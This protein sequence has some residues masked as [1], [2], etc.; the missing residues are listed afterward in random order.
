MNQ[1][2]DHDRHI[3]SSTATKPKT[4]YASLSVTNQSP[5]DVEIKYL[6][7]G[8]EQK[9][10]FPKGS[11]G[12]FDVT[13]QSSSVPGDIEF[14]AYQK[15]TSTIVKMNGGESVKVTPTETKN[16]VAV[17]IGEGSAGGGGGQ[18]KTYYASL[19]VTNQ[20]PNDVEIK[21]LVNGQ[22]QKQEFPKGSAGGFD[23]TVQSSSVP[24][25]I[26]F[27]AYQKGTSTIVK[28]NGGESVKVTPTETKNAVAVTIGEGS[29]G[30]G[31]GQAKTY[32]ASLSVTNQSPNDVEIKY[33]VNGQ[34]QKQEF[35]K[36]SAGG[37][38]VTVQS[39]SVPGDIEF[40]AYQKGT[41]TIVKMNGGESVKVTPTETKN[42]VAVTIGE[43]SAGGGGGQ[44]KT[45]YASLSVTNQ[46]PN[47]VEI[48]Y[49][50]NGQEQKQEFPKG[51]AGGFDVTVQSSSVPGDI[52][53]KAYQKGT[54]TIVKMNGG[55]S[56][57]VTPT[58]TKNAVAV[59]IG[60][61]SAGGGG[62]QAKTYYA[63]LSV[64]NQSPNDV[65]IKYLVNGQEQKQ[66]FPK[67]SAGGF[68]VTVQS[69]SVP[70]DIEFKA[71][72]KGTS[73]IVKM[74]GGESVKVTPTETKNAVAVTIGEGSA[75][76]GGGQA[77]TYYA[78]L[79]VTN[80]SPNDVE[81]KYLVNGQEQK[82]EFPKGS[83]GGFDVTVQSSSV[84]GDIE[85]KA[86]Q[87]GTS[88]IV[89]MNG[90]ES[91]KVT[92]TETKNA[93]AVTIGE[94]S[95]GGGGG[96]AKT[97]YASLSVTNQ[98]PNDVEI[99]YLVNGQEQ[100][101][102]FPK[103]S[104]GGF[105]VTVQSSSVPGD[106]EFKAYQKGT[107]TIVK[108]NGGESVKV[109]PTETKNAVAVTIGEG[110]AGGG[111]GQAKTYY[112]SLSV[113]NQSPNDVEIKYLVNGQEQKQEFPKGSAGGF[114]VTVQSSSV[115]G[116]IEFKAYQKGTST[117]VKMNGGESVKVT[118]TETKNAVAVTI[119]EGSAGGGGGQA[120]TYYASLSVTNQSPNDVEIKYLVNGQEQKQEFPKGSA[121][122]FDVTV[123]SSSVPGDI[124]FK[125]YQKGTS[126]IVK[127]NGGESVKVTPTETKN[128]V[129]VTIG[130]GSAGGGGGQA[131]TYYASLSVTNQ[132][133]NDVEIKYL[134][135][136]QEQKQE[137]PKGS[138]G[139][140]DVTVQS[141]SVPG[142]IEFKAYQKGTSTIVKMNGGESVKVTPTET[143][144]AVAV[145]IGEGSAGG[146]GGQAKTYYASLSVTNQSPNDVEIKYLVNGQ[147]QKQEFPK[148]SAGGFDVTVQSSS[149]P[150]DIEFKAYQKGTSTIVKMNGGE[151]VKVT[152]TETKNAVAVTI[153]EGSAGG[154]GGQAKTYYASLSVTNQSPNDVE[155]KYLVNGQEQKQEFPKGSA[156]GF[157]VTVQSSSVPGDIEFK[158]Y[159]K[160]TS[161]IVKMNGGES[162]KVTPTETK[163]AVA[164]TI[165]EGSAGGGGGQAK[166]YYASLSVTNQSPNDV[167]IKYLVNGQEQKQEFPKGSAGG[168][169]VTVQSS[170]V[171][172]DIEFKAYQKGTSTIV[173]MNG[174]ESVKVTPTE[175]KNAVAVTIGEGSAGGGGGQAKT[176]YASLSVTNQSPNDVEI[177]YL[178]NGQEQKQE[179]PKGSAGGFDVTVQSSSVPGDIEFKA[180]QKGT[181]TIV[182]MN[183]GESVKVTPTETKN[184]VAVTIGEGSAGG[185]GGQAK[186]YY[187]SLSVT[188]QSPNDVEIKYLVNGQEQKQEFPKGSAGGFDVTVQSSSVPG[189]IEFKA[190]QKGTSTIVKMNGG[191]SVKVTPTETKNAVAVTI[192]E[193]SAGG[194]GGQAKTYY[195]SLSVT[196]QSPNDVEIKYLVNGQ[197]QKQEFPKGSAG[198]FDVT[199][200]S[201]SVPG[202]I[203][204]KAYQ[205]G[206]STIVK[207]NG[208][209]SVKVTPTETKNAVAVTIGEGSAGGGGGQ[210]KTYYASLSVTNQSPNDVEIKYLVNGQEQ[211]QEFPKGSAG[212]FDVTVQSSSVPGDI[213]FK[214][215]QKGTSTIVKMNGGESV[216]V[217]P[218][219][220]KNAVAV[221]IGEGSAGG[222]GGQ[223]KTYYASLSVTN[224]SP[225]D[226]E[227]K[228]LVNG[229]EQKQEF[230]KGSAGGFDV[231]VQSS[232]VP[233]DIE[234]KAYQKGTS[235]IVKMN[236]GESV[237]VTPTETKNAV[238]VT[239]GEGSAGGGGGQAKTYY[240][241]LSVT[242]QS[243][244]DVEIKYLV[245]GQEQKQEFPKGSAGG[246]DVTVQSS[247]VP[248]D[249]E[250]KAYQKGTST[251]V[252]MNGGESVKVTPTETKN[253]VAVTI[254]EG[255]AGGGGGQAKTYYASLSV[256]NQ[257]PNDVEIKYLV[258][259]Q[260]QKQEFPKGS[261]GGFDVTVQSSSVPGDIEF[262][263]YQKG[264]STIVKMNGGESVK[265]TPTET[266]N[267][268]AVTIGEGSA[269]G[270][271]GQAKTYY[272]SL[273]VTNQ[274]PNDVEIKYLVN[275]QEQKQEFPK[276]S[277]GGF[278]VTVQSSSVPG[279]IEFKAYQKGTSTI[280]K[281]NGGESVK[282]TP[283]ETKNAVAVTIGEGSAGGGGGQAKTYYASLSVTNQS[284][285]DVEIKYLVNGQ[286]QKQEFP[287]GSAGGFDVTVQSSSVPGDIEFKA[288]QKGTST[289]V[290]MN[291]GESVK[292]TPTET[293]NAV[294]VTIGEGSAGGGGG[295]AKTYYASLSVTNQ[296]PNDVEIKYLVNGQEQKQEFPKGSA[297][298]FDVTVQ[299]S[300]VPGDIE[301]K[302]YQKGTSTIVK[303]NG[304]ESVKV[305]P[306]ETKNAV[307]VTIGGSSGKEG[308]YFEFLLRI[309]VLIF[310][311]FSTRLVLC[312]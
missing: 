292:V 148:G 40:K 22:E 204:F 68:D 287:K 44:A 82:Q 272:A 34:E 107:S 78:S 23:V 89:K 126:T 158:A 302:A 79:S 165:G 295:Q 70:G 151:S 75:G 182:K 290:K 160:G 164:V 117:I 123:Q 72:Q 172:G 235:T 83:A 16:A 122:G 233:G 296:S 271:G 155:I 149:V 197:E 242:N 280:V 105:D 30:G 205:K 311:S 109:T 279:D 69:S 254:G 275:G 173:K 224:Q 140:F 119:G 100:K 263:A 212:G 186:T 116:D 202:D 6:V 137:F 267:A 97:Y 63:S 276:G 299:S 174:G 170:S 184:A 114:D 220:T 17:T 284:P 237:K 246:F 67:G 5:N 10:E 211:K 240:A 142:D 94:G 294:A 171:P 102:E 282:V 239:I 232:S 264:T 90:G 129:A 133:P 31:G 209:E 307:A 53:F 225:N 103:G 127:M 219:E 115:P 260:E 257:S 108:M 179:F 278:D 154:G 20:S 71:Y 206:T 277:A 253:A 291:G 106:I 185:G 297:G 65:E 139:G 132:S 124:E 194:G 213:E 27:K 1:R 248:G 29:A 7:N 24:G 32:Y 13:V 203:E 261:A 21:Y 99:K 81:I 195:A 265:V 283:T 244:N 210:A 55:E 86:Y 201:S 259:G 125:A 134:V 258:N 112:A 85:F 15:G 43:G 61:G 113:T 308:P 273:S 236:G 217:T 191:E 38:D 252:K 48:K 245:N 208:G 66:E 222:G 143:K 176:Y 42:A 230:P 28:M 312:N 46:S 145:T 58:E 18:A 138:A 238:A 181:S 303:M 74:N 14:K 180:Y 33:L 25:D 266:K 60:E 288:Y 262:K 96:Q 8:Q 37:F 247:S 274:S 111:G 309:E 156:G 289:I 128:A 39:S 216:K 19:S 93:V 153:G 136:G 281:M 121:G 152:P 192:G 168:F 88:T 190:Y 243:P 118:P 298:G 80:Q 196:N 177:K 169:D 198:G 110:S 36:G 193:G 120:K 250:F 51:S 268:V 223:A 2:S 167:E 305:T 4:Y 189:D 95:A 64:T 286:E 227:I 9:Q 306:T 301:F 84:P 157:D 11:A 226:V 52:E 231:T 98:S 293:K 101:Q 54:S 35:P 228:Y 256:T 141:S 104:A 229:Q 251:I 234:F 163:N 3:I 12:G 59:T 135:N 146:G 270:G 77:K 207:M 130:E 183:G 26:E 159:Q 304:G 300:S 73:T 175:T 241:S 187:A 147:E 199:V 49:L 215:Y 91:V 45:Y 178:V 255:S 161:T 310:L 249:I 56:V 214:A 41:S 47:D 150:G 131:K 144:N 188:N 200:Q 269:G 221:T 162:V 218:T 62:G 57:K 166:T 92:P 50:V 76:G 285:N 87:K